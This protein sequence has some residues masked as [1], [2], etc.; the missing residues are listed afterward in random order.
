MRAVSQNFSFSFINPLKTILF[1][2]FIIGGCTHFG[3]KDQSVPIPKID[4][5]QSYFPNGN[6]EYEAEFEKGKLDGLSR[7]W[8]ED[9]VLISESD[10]SNGQPHGIWKRYHPI[11][12]I[13][14]EV[15]YEYGK[16]NGHEKWFYEYGQ[17]KSEQEFIHGKP[18]TGI[19]RWKPDGTLVY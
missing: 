18:K 2:F 8:D 9:G 12:S 11:G 16:K 1:L 14:Y 17:V 3:L 19:T 7:V 13:M 15:H 4:V 10:Y 5:E 6:L